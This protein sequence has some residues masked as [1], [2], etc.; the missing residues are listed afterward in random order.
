[1]FDQH[2][3]INKI[4][5]CIAAYKSILEITTYEL[6]VDHAIRQCLVNCLT[7]FILKT[8]YKIMVVIIMISS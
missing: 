1:M 2:V 7:F 5:C 3:H 8:R 4:M 6:Y